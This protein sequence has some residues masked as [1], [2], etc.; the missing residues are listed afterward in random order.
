MQYSTEL[1]P[2]HTVLPQVTSTLWPPGTAGAVE[3]GYSGEGADE[4]YSGA[5]ADEGY[6]GAGAGSGASV[7]EGVTLRHIFVPQNVW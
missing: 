4:G 2:P 7:G 5:C 3:V 6:S 1:S